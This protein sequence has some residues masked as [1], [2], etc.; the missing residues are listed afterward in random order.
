TTSGYSSIWDNIGAITNKGV[1]LGLHTIN[2]Q[3]LHGFGWTSDLNVTWNRNRVTAL[4]GGE[5]ITYTVSSRV[6]SIVA[7]GKPIGEYYM[8]KFLRVDPADGNAVFATAGGGESKSPTAS[9][10]MMVG[11][12]QPKYYGGFTNTFSLGSLDLRGFLQFSQGNKVFN[13]MRIFTDDGGWSYDN[14][15]T[16]ELNRWQKP[17]DVTDEPR[18]SYDGTSGARLMSSRMIEDGSFLRL[19][20]VT[21]G[22]HL[23]ARLSGAA[24][25]NDA[26]VFVSGRNLKTWTKYTGYNPDV[27]SA[28]VL[29][30]VVMGVDYYAYPLAR[31]FN[32]GLSAGW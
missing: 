20:E 9:D 15:S 28:G 12:P 2:L 26:R 5:P 17:G 27:N 14:K 10:L 22:Y 11:N 24:R 19:G 7:V 13:M 29:A 21:L 1:D 30:N 18:M 23:P 6:T 32:V 25:L 4:Y 31:T 3:N 16:L 8:Y